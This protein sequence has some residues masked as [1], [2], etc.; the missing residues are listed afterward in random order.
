MPRRG[1]LGVQR[2]EGDGAAGDV[3]CVCQLAHRRD[4]VGLAVN[5]V[6]SQHQA[7]AMLHGR[8]QHAAAVFGLLGG[9]AD[10]LPIHGDRRGV[11]GPE[12]LRRPAL[13]ACIFLIRRDFPW[14]L[15]LLPGPLR[16]G[17]FQRVRRQAREDV[18]E[19]RDRRRGVALPTGAV[20]AAR[21]LELLLAQQAGEL[22][23]GRH[24]AVAG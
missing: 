5:L 12:A 20:K 8:D 7:A 13:A 21:G 24:A 10:I 2:V 11:P 22:R 16:H 23:E 4:L 18:V 1:V 17:R 14:I 15:A 9:A 19:R 3:E 6:L